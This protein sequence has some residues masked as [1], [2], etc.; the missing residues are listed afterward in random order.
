MDHQIHFS[1]FLL[2]KL[3]ENMHQALLLTRLF[4]TTLLEIVKIEL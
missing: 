3:Y 1:G 4:I 2:L